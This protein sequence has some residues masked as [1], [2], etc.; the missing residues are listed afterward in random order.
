[1][2]EKIIHDFQNCYKSDNPNFVKVN[3]KTHRPTKE[4]NTDSIK[5]KGQHSYINL[6]NDKCTKNQL[7]IKN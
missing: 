3:K 1:M 5:K 2:S 4:H 7:S 6:N